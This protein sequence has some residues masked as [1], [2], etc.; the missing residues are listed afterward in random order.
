MVGRLDTREFTGQRETPKFI[1]L[2]T[3]VDTSQNV[4]MRHYL[5]SQRLIFKLKGEVFFFIVPLLGE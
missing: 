5:Q 1:S 2:T 4:T 3:G